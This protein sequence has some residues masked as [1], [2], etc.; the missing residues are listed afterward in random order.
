VAA[1]SALQIIPVIGVL[2]ENGNQINGSMKNSTMNY[3]D[4]EYFVYH[5]DHA[6]KGLFFGKPMQRRL[7]KEWVIT[8]SRRWNKPD[9]SFGGVIS[10][11]DRSEL[12][13]GFF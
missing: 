6:D 11:R 12:F 3:S 9:G 1:T 7:N 4:R 2:D 8:L 5:R 13:S 10:R